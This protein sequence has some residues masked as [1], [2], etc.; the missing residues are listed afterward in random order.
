M[1]L[2]IAA[3]LAGCSSSPPPMATCADSLAGTWRGESGEWMLLDRG[4]ALEGYPLFDDSREPGADP[5][6]V[7]APRAID[8]R[9]QGDAVSG[10]ISRRYTRAGDACTARVP[11]RVLTCSGQTIDVILAD[12]S[13]PTQFTPCTESARKNPSRREKWQRTHP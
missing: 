4:S 2:V 9:R 13:S 3:A 12:T 1:R 8:L 11:F 6:I 10:E 7:V 5:T